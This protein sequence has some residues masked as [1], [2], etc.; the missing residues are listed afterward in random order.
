MIWYRCTLHTAQPFKN[1]Y[2]FFNFSNSFLILCPIL[3][4]NFSTLPFGQTWRKEFLKG[5]KDY[6]K[7]MSLITS[8]ATFSLVQT[9][10]VPWKYGMF[11][12]VQHMTKKTPPYGR[13][14]WARWCTPSPPPG[15]TPQSSPTKQTLSRWEGWQL[16]S[17]YYQMHLRFNPCVRLSRSLDILRRI[18][19]VVFILKIQQYL[20][21]KWNPSNLI[22]KRGGVRNNSSRYQ[23]LMSMIHFVE[24]KQVWDRTLLWQRVV[25]CFGFSLL[26]IKMLVDLKGCQVMRCPGQ[27]NQIQSC[28]SIKQ[29]TYR[30]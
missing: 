25:G 8:L 27:E 26:K 2:H 13:P 23:V 17:N 4:K 22:C 6:W 29:P 18:G 12:D 30:S 10:C 5:Q 7:E 3:P 14:P 9:S 11:S 21:Q 20:M 24:R 19:E 15:C 1:F 28:D 16:L